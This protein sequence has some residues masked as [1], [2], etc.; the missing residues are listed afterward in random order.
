MND[1]I[2]ELNSVGLRRFALTTSCLLIGVFGIVLPL[3]YHRHWPLWPWIVAVVL[4][5]WGVFLPL[6]LRMLYQLWMTLALFLG[7]VNSK[8]LLSVLFICVIS[9]VGF[10]MRLFGYDPLRQKYLTHVLSYRKPSNIQLHNHME[11]PY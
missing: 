3:L 1:D 5:L 11:K 10:L 7:G 4:T 6:H 8:V 2:P 9:P